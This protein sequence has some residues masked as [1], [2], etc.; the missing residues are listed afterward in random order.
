MT[1]NKISD[2]SDEWLRELNKQ[3]RPVAKFSRRIIQTS[4][5][6][7]LDS[8][9]DLYYIAPPRDLRNISYTHNPKPTTLADG[10][11]LLEIIQTY[12][13]I[14]SHFGASVAEV[15]SQIPERDLAYT[16]AYEVFDYPENFPHVIEDS[17][18][19]AKTI[20][21]RMA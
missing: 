14:T 5:H 20:L 9:G 2:I 3:M 10:L 16:V 17:H 12:H 4:D 18:F 7:V 8:A 21:Y 1:P 6:M 19:V 15:I 11:E 13:T